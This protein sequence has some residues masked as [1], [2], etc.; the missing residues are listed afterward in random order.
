EDLTGDGA[1]EG[2]TLGPDFWQTAK[3]VHPDGGKERLTVRFDRDIVDW[4]RAQGRGYQTRMNAVLRAY[5][6]AKKS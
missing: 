3:V 5:V 4:F 1:P 2:P 6:E